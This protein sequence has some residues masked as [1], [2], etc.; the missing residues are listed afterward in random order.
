MPSIDLYD[1]CIQHQSDCRHT[2]S[3]MYY[4]NYSPRKCHSCR[5]RSPDRRPHFPSGHLRCPD[6]QSWRYQRR[7]SRY[8]ESARFHS[9]RKGYSLGSLHRS[10][11]RCQHL[12][13][14]LLRDHNIGFAGNT[15]R[16]L[17]QGNTF[18]I[19]F[20]HGNGMMLSQIMG[21]FR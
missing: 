17:R 12:R 3:W 2:H 20:Y 1:S 6:H 7:C 13:S 16:Y 15:A 9:T 21:H 4:H 8:E 18:C 11:T 14:G 5:R 10:Q 19:I